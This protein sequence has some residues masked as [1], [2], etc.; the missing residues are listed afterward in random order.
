MT[1]IQNTVKMKK[2]ILNTLWKSLK[3]KKEINQAVKNVKR[4]TPKEKLILKTKER[5]TANDTIQSE[6]LAKSFSKYSYFK[7]VWS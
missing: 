2:I 7:E 1:E 5:H 3:K 6:S 4:I